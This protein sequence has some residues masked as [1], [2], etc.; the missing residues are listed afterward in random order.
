MSPTQCL[1]TAKLEVKFFTYACRGRNES[2]IE[3]G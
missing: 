2:N 3:Q 1:D